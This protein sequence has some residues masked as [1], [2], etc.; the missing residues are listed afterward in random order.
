[1]DTVWVFSFNAFTIFLLYSFDS[2]V[3]PLVFQTELFFYK[4]I[5]IQE[6]MRLSGSHSLLHK[7]NRI[8][9]HNI[10]ADLCE[11]VLIQLAMILKHLVCL[12]PSRLTMLDL[13]R[14]FWT[15]FR[16]LSL[17]LYIFKKKLIKAPF[18]KN[19]C[20]WAGLDRSL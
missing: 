6:T 14:I 8:Q 1:M 2:Q 10:R 18:F 16:E 11:L 7:L 13:L 12:E 20:D 9:Y 19:K 3:L 17:H 4:L 5:D 15:Q